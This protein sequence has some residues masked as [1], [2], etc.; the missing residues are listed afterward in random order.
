MSYNGF[1]KGSIFCY[2]SIFHLDISTFDPLKSDHQYNLGNNHILYNLSIYLDTP[3]IDSIFYQKNDLLSKGLRILYIQTQ[4][5]MNT[6][7]LI[8]VIQ[9]TFL[10]MIYKMENPRLNSES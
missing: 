10:V 6:L 1:N 2:A 5:I 3:S 4:L 8:Q 9:Q 7:S